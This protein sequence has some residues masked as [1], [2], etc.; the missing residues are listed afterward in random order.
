MDYYIIFSLAVI[1][2]ALLFLFLVWLRKKFALRESAL[3]KRVDK[4]F[5]EISQLLAIDNESAFRTAIIEA[6]KLLD[7]VLKSKGVRGST[8][9]ERLKSSRGLIRDLNNIWFAHKVRNRLVHDLDSRIKRRE[10]A[11]VIKIFRGTINHLLNL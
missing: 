8:L 10:T 3:K 7:F 1:V 9:G 11:R 5:K 4:K 2:L 6:D